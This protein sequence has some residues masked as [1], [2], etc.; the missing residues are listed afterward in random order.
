MQ[1]LMLMFAA[2]GLLVLSGCGSTMP[3]KP[4]AAKAPEKT[5][6]PQA[7]LSDE[8]KQALAQA[9]A[10]VKAAQE[11]KALWTTAQDALKQAKEAAK[12]N[13][14][15]AV[16]NIAKQAS[17]YAKLGIAQTQYPLTTISK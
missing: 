16:I 12:N 7:Q 13:D 1:K 3:T 17:E 2:A 9:E 4:Q 14:S 6:A 15:A 10:D 8:A 11:K 5:E